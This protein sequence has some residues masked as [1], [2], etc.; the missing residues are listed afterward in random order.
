MFEIEESHRAE[1]VRVLA[2]EALAFVSAASIASRV[3]LRAALVLVRFAPLI[4]FLAWRPFDRLDLVARRAVLARLERSMLS[5]VLVAW[6]TILVLH[7]YEDARELA[8]IG[9]RDERKRHLAVIPAAAISGIRLREDI[10]V[11]ND[12]DDIDEK[13]AA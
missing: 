9:Y 8:R 13:G 6:R 4:F 5:L 7:F 10:D 12:D 1:R 11:A 3:G 2:D